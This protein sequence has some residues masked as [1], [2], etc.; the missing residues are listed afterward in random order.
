MKFHKPCESRAHEATIAWR[1]FK[2][3]AIQR[4]YVTHTAIVETGIA[5]DGRICRAP[6]QIIRCNCAVFAGQFSISFR[7]EPNKRT[8]NRQRMCALKM[9]AEN[10]RP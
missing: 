6:A 5:R 4:I 10:G 9:I 8:A 2:A 3:F 7:S 1:A